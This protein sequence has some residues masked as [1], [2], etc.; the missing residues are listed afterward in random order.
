MKRYKPLEILSNF[1]I[2]PPPHERKA[3]LVKIS[4]R[5]F[6]SERSTEIEYIRNWTDHLCREDL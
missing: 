4:W 6:C 2:K 5:R 3:P 1:N